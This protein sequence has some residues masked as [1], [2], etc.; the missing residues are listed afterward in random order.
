[1]SNA[2][3]SLKSAV[4]EHPEPLLATEADVIG[5]RIGA[6]LV[7]A[8]VVFTVFYGGIRLLGVQPS[9]GTPA[10]VLGFLFWYVFSV[11]GFS[12]LLVIYGFSPLWYLFAVGIWAAYATLLETLFGQ[13]IGKWLF[14]LVVVTDEGNPCSLPAALVRNLLRTVDGLFFYGIGFLVVAVTSRRQRL[15]DWGAN[16]VVLRRDGCSDRRLRISFGL[17]L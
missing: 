8:V 12:P 1:M 17:L 5:Q 11:L 16:T 2:S 13:T 7:D 4:F 15:G 3:T 9:V 10:V 14:D 6:A